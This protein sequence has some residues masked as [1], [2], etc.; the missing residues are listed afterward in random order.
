MSVAYIVVKPIFHYMWRETSD[1]WDHVELVFQ[2]VLFLLTIVFVSGFANDCWCTPPWQ[3]QIGA[4]VMFMAYFNLILLLKAM[5][6][7]GV[8]VPINMLL[9]IIITFVKLAFLPVL[10]VLAFGFPFYMLF[11]R[12]RLYSSS[13]ECTSQTLAKQHYPYFALLCLCGYVR[14]C[15]CVSKYKLYC[16]IGRVLNHANHVY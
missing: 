14:V 3:W 2:I 13:V 8:G 1:I 9:N 16:S 15:M 4:L 5:P 7:L 10:L 11:V 6:L 12:V